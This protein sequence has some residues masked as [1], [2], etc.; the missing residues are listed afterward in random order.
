MR[1]QHQQ[2][3]RDSGSHRQAG[4]GA[5]VPP[6]MGL[7]VGRSCSSSRRPLLQSVRFLLPRKL[8]HSPKQTEFGVRCPALGPSQRQGAT[9]VG[10]SC[11][12][13]RALPDALPFSPASC[14][15]MAQAPAYP[16]TDRSAA[17]SSSVSASE[18]RLPAATSL[19]GGACEGEKV[20]SAPASVRVSRRWNLASTSASS[21]T[22]DSSTKAT[23]LTVWVMHIASSRRIG[24]RTSDRQIHTNN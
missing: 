12:S 13:S 1:G 16:S 9:T 21:C 6:P 14:S 17:E 24:T 11:V 18:K 15:R 22:D 20:R 5:S 19:F 10:A 23:I 3:V 7:C 8:P 4:R 2:R